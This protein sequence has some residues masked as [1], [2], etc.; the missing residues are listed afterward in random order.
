[1][2][3]NNNL[4]QMVVN[5]KAF[6]ANALALSVGDKNFAKIFYNELERLG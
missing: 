1:M 4:K 3:L 5:G 2:S 6:Y